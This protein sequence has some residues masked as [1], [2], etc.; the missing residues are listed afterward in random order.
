MGAA[1]V[2]HLKT[3]I[4]TALR[5]PIITNSRP[6]DAEIEAWKKETETQFCP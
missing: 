3:D 2:E 1:H 4:S 6:S 5:F